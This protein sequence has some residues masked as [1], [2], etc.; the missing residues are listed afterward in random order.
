MDT[1]APAQADYHHV[2]AGLG[3]ML[4]I[5]LLSESMGRILD[6]WEFCCGWL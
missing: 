1:R 5:V 6:I 4:M 2:Q 3:A